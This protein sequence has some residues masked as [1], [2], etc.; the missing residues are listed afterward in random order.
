MLVLHIQLHMHAES[1][2][3]QTPISRK[4]AA[5]PLL[6]S[7]FDFCVDPFVVARV[8]AAEL[9]LFKPAHSPFVSLKSCKPFLPLVFL[10]LFSMYL[11]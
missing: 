4:R 1:E 9:I 7:D 10:D 6:C 3:L 5:T 11:K 2:A 8:L